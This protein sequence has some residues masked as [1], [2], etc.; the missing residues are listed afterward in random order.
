MIKFYDENMT[1]AFKRLLSSQI[2]FQKARNDIPLSFFIKLGGASST[3]ELFYLVR[4]DS[5]GNELVTYKLES[6]LISYNAQFDLLQGVADLYP[7]N[8]LNG[9]YQIKIKTSE[10]E[11]QSEPFDIV[12]YG[13]EADILHFVDD[14]YQMT[15]LDGFPISLINK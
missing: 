15:F 14:G 11:Y 1:P 8:I 4:I 6:S 9:T 12:S 7:R 5:R 3:I 2:G 13:F 10:H